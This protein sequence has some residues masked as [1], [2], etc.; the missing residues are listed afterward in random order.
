MGNFLGLI[1]VVELTR[2]LKSVWIDVLHHE[3]AIFPDISPVLLSMIAGFA[4]MWLCSILDAGE[5]ARLDRAGYETQ[6][7]RSETGIGAVPTFRH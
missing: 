2:L 5:R 1:T 6:R 4:G 3:T 7:V